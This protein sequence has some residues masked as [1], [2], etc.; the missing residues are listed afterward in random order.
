MTAFSTMPHLSD[1]MIEALVPSRGRLF[2]VSGPSGVGKGTV[3]AGML[4]SPSA[5]TGLVKCTTA[6]TRAPRPGEVDGVN[7]E[8]F[9]RAEFERKIEEGYFLEHAHYNDNLYGTPL[10]NVEREREAGQDILL[11]IEVQGGVSVRKM[12]PEAVLVFL[13]PP[14]R[15]ELERR[16]RCRATDDPAAVEKRLAIAM[17][18]MDAAPDYDY[19]IVN[20]SVEQAV[21]ELRA[22]IIAERR[23][24]RTDGGR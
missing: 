6:T 1:N 24:I 11:E 15:Q 7:Y 4:R 9:S 21:D 20:G 12:D 18:E 8:F 10:P 13:A 19:L 22:V 17:R 16:L 2:V 23:R 14:S 3:I 5:P